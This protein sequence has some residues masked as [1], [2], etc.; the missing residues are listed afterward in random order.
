M[1]G[2][3]TEPDGTGGADLAL[4]RAKLYGALVGVFGGSPDR[5]LV[6]AL[7]GSELN[8]LLEILRSLDHPE[9][10]S[11]ADR[12]DA[13]RVASQYKSDDKIFN[14]LAV[15]RTRILRPSGHTDLKPPCE[16][17]YRRQEEAVALAVKQ[18]YRQA[19]LLPE[20]TTPESPDYLG[21]E[22]DFLRQ[23]CLREH[24]QLSAAAD[25]SRTVAEEERFL[26]EHLGSWIGDYVERAR[27]CART[28]FYGGFLMILKTVIAIDKEYLGRMQ[29]TAEASLREGSAG[30]TDR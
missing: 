3:Q 10:R 18:C 25:A 17:A 2:R 24:K 20:E 27:P 26:R 13:Y 1:D 12:V 7:R 9:L 29:T 5:T 14:E 16:G 19:G 21:V 8:E 15:D 6:A 11:G 22:L 23:L 4:G 28:D 30:F